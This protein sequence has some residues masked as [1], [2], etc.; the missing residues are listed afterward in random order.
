VSGL[1][2]HLLFL[3]RKWHFKDWLCWF[4]FSCKGMGIFISTR[5]MWVFKHSN[6]YSD[7]PAPL[8]KLTHFSMDK[9]SSFYRG[10]AARAWSCQSPQS[11]VRLKNKCCYTSAQHICPHGTSICPAICKVLLNITLM[12]LWCLQ[13][14]AHAIFLTHVSTNPKWSQS[15]ADIECFPTYS[16]HNQMFLQNSFRSKIYFA[17]IGAFL[18]MSYNGTVNLITYLLTY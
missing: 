1:C 6:G 15:R 7:L 3:K 11:S 4:Q 16:F 17:V 8:H 5:G 12:F 10:E 9:R 2:R 14:H 13:S 18:S